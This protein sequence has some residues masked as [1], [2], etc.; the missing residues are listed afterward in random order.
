MLRQIWKTTKKTSLEVA[1]KKYGKIYSSSKAAVRYPVVRVTNP[2]T[3]LITQKMKSKV[4]IF[5]RVASTV[6]CQWSYY[7]KY[8]MTLISWSEPPDKPI[9]KR[10]WPKPMP[11]VFTLD[12]PLETLLDYNFVTRV[13]FLPFLWNEREEERSWKRGCLDFSRALTWLWEPK[14]N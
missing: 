14:W 12:I 2:D 7:R 3:I 4:V 8:L 13:S 10:I 9:K 6:Q 5:Y 11:S 1:K